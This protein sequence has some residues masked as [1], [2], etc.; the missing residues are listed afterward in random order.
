VTK[1]LEEKEMITYDITGE[2]NNEWQGRGPKT[3]T[4]AI[5]AVLFGVSGPF[6]AGALLVMSWN[7][8]LKIGNTFI[9]E[10]KSY[11]FGTRFFYWV[12]KAL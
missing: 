7:N 9:V 8:F 10:R 1:S 5:M 6:S 12:V 11:G 3:S 4:L 2:P